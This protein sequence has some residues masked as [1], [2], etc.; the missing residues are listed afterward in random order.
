[1]HRLIFIVLAVLL[2]A[3]PANA[4][5]DLLLG[6]DL[7]TPRMVQAESPSDKS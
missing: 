5:Q 4:E 7:N 2:G 1:M 6:V 3:G